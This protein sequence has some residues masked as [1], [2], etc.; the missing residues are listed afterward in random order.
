MGVLDNNKKAYF[1]YT[2]VDDFV[3]GI[4]LVGSEIKPIKAGFVSIKE[5]YCYIDKGELFIKGMHVSVSKESGV[6]D[7][8]DPYRVRK[9]LMNK[10]EILKLEKSI[11]AKGMTIVPLNIHVNKVGLIKVKIG[12]CKGKKLYDKRETMKKRDVE[13]DIQR[14]I[15]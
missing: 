15:K 11:A 6:Y 13:R 8:H 5:G 12:L 14:S 3:T 10:K 1:E 7:N 4:K 9:L 2:V